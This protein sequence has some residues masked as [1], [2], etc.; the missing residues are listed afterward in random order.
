[1]GVVSSLDKYKQF[2]ERKTPKDILGGFRVD[3]SALN[4][5][6]FDFQKFAVSKALLHGR[7]ALLEDCG[8]GKTWQQIEWAVQVVKKINKP[9][10]ILAPLGVTGQT[11]KVGNQMGVDIARVGVRKSDS[12]IYITNYEQ[13]DN[14][15]PANYCALILDESSI[16]KNAEGKIK[17]KIISAFNSFEYKL[18][19]TATPSPNDDME[20]TNHAEFLNH[21]ARNTI[22]A[23]YFTHD[24]GDTSK[25]RLKGHAKQRFWNF[26]KT[27]SLF[28]SNP[29]DIGFDGSKYVL[30]ELRMLEHKID[31]P[32]RDGRLF[33]DIHVNATSFNAELKTTM[34]ERMTEVGLL[35]M[36]IKDPL[37]IWIKH[38]AEAD[39]IVKNIPGA[40]DVRGTERPEAKEE[41]LLGFADGDFRI[42]VTKKRMAAYGL[43][44]QHCHDQIDASPDY[45]FEGTYQ[46][47]RRSYRFGQLHPV[48]YRMIVTDTMRNVTESFNRKLTQYED[49]KHY[50]IAA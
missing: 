16:L 23:T 45:S 8:L 37:I 18:A 14:I 15:D 22:L 20:F 21:G 48:T 30:P 46:A 12:K 44:Y 41:K 35:A 47:I 40:V 34:R 26:V 2:I 42:M 49:M 5:L 17:T 43:N 29:C 33:N 4:P 39:W 6:L 32:T 25:W 7:Y 10:L 31:T 19:C 50:L 11:V 38:N 9:V 36:E 3:E 27:M 24:G 1:M 13:L 28:I